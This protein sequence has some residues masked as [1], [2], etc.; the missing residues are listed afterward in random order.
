M[1]SCTGRVSNELAWPHPIIFWHVSTRQC[2][3]LGQD[4]WEL[5]H[6]SMHRTWN[7]WLH[8]GRSSMRSPVAKSD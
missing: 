5:N 7:P 4:E 2:L 1:V 8:F 6:L 3:H